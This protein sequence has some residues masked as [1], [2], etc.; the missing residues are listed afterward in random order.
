MAV[1]D[2]GGAGRR[3]RDVAGPTQVAA[4]GEGWVGCCGR[5][6]GW[7]ALLSS[8]PYAS[9]VSVECFESMSSVHVVRRFACHSALWPFG[10]VV[11][12]YVLPIRRS[13]AG[14]CFWAPFVPIAWVVSP[15]SV[16][17]PQAKAA[18]STTV[19]QI[20]HKPCHPTIVTEMRQSPLSAAAAA[21]LFQAPVPRRDSFMLL[22]AP[23]LLL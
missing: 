12:V 14:A 1:G 20:R 15:N 3:S 7:V 10:R 17:Q 6:D 2:H 22:L 8:Y 4:A 18:S 13:T 19:H 11:V 21:I 5:D 16:V 9:Y 23:G